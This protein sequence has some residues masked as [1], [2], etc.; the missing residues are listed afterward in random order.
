MRAG[1]LFF[2]YFLFAQAKESDLLPST[3]HG[4]KTHHTN[5]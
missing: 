4:G 1:V 3:I 5:Y 2:D